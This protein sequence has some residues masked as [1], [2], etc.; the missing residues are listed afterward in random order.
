M[1]LA[2]ICRLYIRIEFVN[3]VHSTAQ[4]QNRMYILHKLYYDKSKVHFDTHSQEVQSDDLLVSC[5]SNFQNSQRLTK[6]CPIIS[7]LAVES[8]FCKFRQMSNFC[9]IQNGNVGFTSVYTFIGELRA[10]LDHD[11]YLTKTGDN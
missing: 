9:K 10:C 5:N 3:K 11:E 1:Y 4:N 6:A 2:A 7:Q 8:E